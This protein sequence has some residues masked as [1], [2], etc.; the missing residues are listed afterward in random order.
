MQ[1][2]KYLKDA[3]REFST[4]QEFSMN[5]YTDSFKVSGHSRTSFR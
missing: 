5:E 4:T 1:E 3:L 2:Y